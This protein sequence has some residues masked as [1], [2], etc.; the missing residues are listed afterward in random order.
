MDHS[1]PGSSIHEILKAR[2]LK[3]V[4]MPSSRESSQSRNQTRI[5][6]ISF[7]G[8]QVLYHYCHLSFLRLHF[9]QIPKKGVNSFLW[10]KCLSYLQVCGFTYDFNRP[11]F[12]STSLISLQG[13]HTQ[14]H[15]ETYGILKQSVGEGNG[16]PLQYS[17]LENFVGTGAWWA[18]VY[19]V[20]KSQT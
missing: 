19:G 7:I 5:S 15:R 6:Y 3:W 13:T 16:N 1:L 9:F 14:H 17:C 12:S 18:T 8:R 2:I 10:K 20:A 4:A 11:S